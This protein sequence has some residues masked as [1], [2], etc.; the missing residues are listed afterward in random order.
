MPDEIEPWDWGPER[1][2]LRS[3][4]PRAGALVDY[5]EASRARAGRRVE[6]MALTA[7]EASG[8]DAEELLGRIAESE[9]LSVLFAI[10]VEAARRSQLQAKVRALGRAVASGAL[11]ADEATVDEAQLV[12]ATLATLEAPH[13]RALLLLSK[14]KSDGPSDE[15]GKPTETGKADVPTAL[16]PTRER[17]VAELIR[18]GLGTTVEASEAI[19]AILANNGLVWLDPPG[20]AGWGLTAY[21][22]RILLVLDDHGRTREG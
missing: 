22:A 13:I 3:L 4:S 21:G 12:A 17:T 14:A 20:F 10:A 5:A 8:L 16:K 2:L 7:V 19:L 15:A 18:K 6:E 9:Q 11:A 1:A